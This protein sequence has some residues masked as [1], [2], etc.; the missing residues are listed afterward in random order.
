[1]KSHLCIHGHFYQ[2]P[3]EDPWL[4]EILPEGSAAPFLNWN[5]RITRESYTP[6]AY[7][8]IMADGD[9]T[10]EILNVYEWISFNFGPTLL[11]LMQDSAPD[12]YARILEGDV[13]SAKR[14]GFGNALAQVYHHVIMPLASE[15]DKHL[16][17]AWAVHD[18]EARFGRKPDGIW[19][20][21]TAV[22]VAS[23]DVFAHYD[24]AFT[25][26]APSQARAVVQD[27][28]EV[29]VNEHELDKRKAYRV[30]L[31]SGKSM[32]VFF[33]DGGL[34]Q[35]VAFERLLSDGEHFRKR[36]FDACGGGLTSIAT[37]GETYGHHFTFGE[38]ALA[39]VLKKAAT[40][41]QAPDLTNYAAYLAAH[42]PTQEVVLH[43]KSAW[44]CVHGVERWNSD[45]GCNTG[46]NPGWN[47]KW[48]TPLREGL[49]HMKTRLDE[50]FFHR[51]ETLFK[52]A[53]KA[54]LDYG[55]LLSGSSTPEGFAGMHFLPGLK[56]EDTRTAWKLL[57]MQ[58]SALASF[59]SCAWF[60][61]DIAGLEPV[62]GMTFACRA[63]E[64]AAQSGL[65]SSDALEAQVLAIFEQAV[66]N[67]FPDKTGKD[68][69]LERA[70]PRKE[71]SASLVSQ[72][73]L[74]SWSTMSEQG[75]KENIVFTRPNVEVSL[76]LTPAPGVGALSGTA[77]LRSSFESEGEKI[78]WH[79]ER[80]DSHNPLAGEIKTT[81]A[82]SAKGADAGERFVPDTLP[83][84]KKQALALI[85]ARSNEEKLWFQE[86]LKAQAGVGLFLPLQTAQGTQNDEGVW[87][88]MWQGLAW[89]YLTMDNEALGD[90]PALEAFLQVCAEKQPDH[91]LLDRRI[92]E[93]LLKRLAE[94]PA[95]TEGVER[96]LEGIAKLGLNV[97]LWAVRNVVWNKGIH[98]PGLSR[99][100]DLLGF[101]V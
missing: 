85:W 25:I 19:A 93:E 8:R 47:Q 12:T 96:M 18:F 74:E 23:L 21:E 37:D 95:E 31:P 2:P 92:G 41:P 45:C 34:S 82:A 61:D 59:A 60:F 27:G 24:I 3:R 87:V 14:C 36:L 72:A 32:A 76:S 99:I 64:L 97:D 90:V 89:C 79:W 50:H 101:A 100:A 20:S 81:S 29:P 46:G 40:D 65:E 67:E 1:M 84:N 30:R 68:L 39:Y 17:T 58:E 9:R 91:K 88:R 6:L 22:D 75:A 28:Q 70:K 42:P 38:M 7:A 73:L 51:G 69:Y 53:D 10:A 49:N 56:A 83:W 13:A 16:E 35:A 98:S 33:Y 77:M 94:N 66:S 11:R 15:R 5:E 54:L 62:N 52:D 78:T 80:S 63:M 57:A 26:L 86:L 48:R 4:G 55:L 44:S 43:E 71:S